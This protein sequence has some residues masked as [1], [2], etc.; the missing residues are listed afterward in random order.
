MTEDESKTLKPGDK[1]RAISDIFD[2]GFEIGKTYDVV[3]NSSNKPCIKIEEES[4]WFIYE[5]K[6]LYDFE[7]V[8]PENSTLWK[9]GKKYKL[10]NGDEYTVVWIGKKHIILIDQHENCHERELT[11]QIY[12]HTETEY[13][14]M[15][16]DR[17]LAILSA[18]EFD[19]EEE[20]RAAYQNVRIVKI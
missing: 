17:Y 7:I 10:R 18:V 14:L 1:V 15:P 5:T 2:V 16:P 6:Y 9:V 4:F 12:H 11:G 19:S 13:D 20:A 8:K 3:F